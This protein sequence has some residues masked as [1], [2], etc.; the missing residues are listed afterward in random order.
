MGV[1]LLELLLEREGDWERVPVPEGE[2]EGVP[3]GVPLTDEPGDGVAGIVPV[4]EAATSPLMYT[5][6]NL[7]VEPVPLK[8]TARQQNPGAL[9]ASA[10]NAVSN[11]SSHAVLPN[12]V[13]FG[14]AGTA[15]NVPL[16]PPVEYRH[17]TNSGPEGGAEPGRKSAPH[18]MFTKPLV[19]AQNSAACVATAGEGKAGTGTADSFATVRQKPRPAPTKPP[20]GPVCDPK[21]KLRLPLSLPNPPVPAPIHVSSTFVALPTRLSEG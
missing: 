20:R 2:K 4:A 19:G 5:P 18:T 14:A 1:P 3:E 8:P 9:A 11:A 10:G 17:C 21:K 6:S 7:S 15:A 13:L 12:V 16:G